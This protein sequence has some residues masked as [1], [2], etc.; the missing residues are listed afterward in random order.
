[1]KLI[2][3]KLYFEVRKRINDKMKLKC[4]TP[5]KQGDDNLP[6]TMRGSSSIT[7]RDVTEVPPP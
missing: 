3:N 6:P 4:F 7:E 5:P 1:M 2:L